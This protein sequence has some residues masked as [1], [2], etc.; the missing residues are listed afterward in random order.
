V[1]DVFAQPASVR[2]IGAA[3]VV[4]EAAVKAHLLNLYDKFSVHQSG[5]SRRSQLA[6]DALRRRAVTLADLRDD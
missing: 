2:D 5:E 6:R 1:K 3:L 4:S